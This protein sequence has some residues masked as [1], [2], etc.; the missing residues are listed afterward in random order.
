MGQPVALL[1]FEQFNAFD[2]ARLVLRDGTF[3]KSG[4]ETGPVVVP[5]YGLRR[6]TVP[7]LRGDR[8]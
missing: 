7:E 8:R 1:I 6:R 5:N 3:V 4:E 2:R